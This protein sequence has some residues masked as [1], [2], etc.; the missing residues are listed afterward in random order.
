MGKGW[1]GNFFEDFTVGQKWACPTPRTIRSGDAALYTALTGDRT[2]AYCGPSGLV[3]PLVTFHAVFGQTVRYISLNAR[4]NLGYAGIVWGAPVAL[5]DTLSTT[6][7]V[8][9]LKENSTKT[10]GVVYVHTVGRNQKGDE[11]L[12]FWRWVMVHKRGDAPTP[13][14]DAPVVPEMP[15]AVGPDV[16]TLSTEALST[17]DETGG[18]YFFEDYAKGERVLHGDGMAVNPSDHMSFTR[19]FQNSAKVHFDLRGMNGKPLV[20][21]GYIISI[22]Y[23]AAFNGFENR[24]GIAGIN[25]GSHTAPCFAG[26]TVYAFTDVVDSYDPGHDWPIGALRCRLIAVKNADVSEDFAVQVE[27]PEKPGKP[28]LNPAV[29]LDLDFWEWVAKR[30]DA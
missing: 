30:P 5:G 7:E 25:A 24:L 2:P 23:A 4:A 3:H 14:L 9:G 22:A 10:T 29:V 16:L 12:S 8:V 13:Y 17:P 15:K 1:S 11:V 27:D 19:L 28:K 18:H 20:Y 26:D 21:G 6:L